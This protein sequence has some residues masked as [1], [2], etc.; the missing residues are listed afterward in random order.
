M[1][2]NNIKRKKFSQRFDAAID[3]AFKES[4]GQMLDIS[5]L[6]EIIYNICPKLKDINRRRES[7][8]KPA[9]WVRI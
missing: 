1:A 4:K 7:S 5:I 3:K 2:K 6:G 9:K 8:R